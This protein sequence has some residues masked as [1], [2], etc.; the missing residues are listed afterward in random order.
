MAPSSCI[1]TKIHTPR[2]PFLFTLP[3]QLDQI[4]PNPSPLEITH[5]Y[6]NFSFYHHSPNPESSLLPCESW[7]WTAYSRCGV[8][9]FLYSHMITC[10]TLD[11]ISLKNHNT[12]FVVL[13]AATHFVCTCTICIQLVQVHFYSSRILWICNSKKRKSN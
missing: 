4:S 11:E 5:N 8:T 2:S 13:L 9:K 7:K 12:Q 6:Q 3:V 10:L 1:K